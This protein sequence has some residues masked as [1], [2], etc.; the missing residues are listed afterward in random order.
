MKRERRNFFSVQASPGKTERR[1]R[2][3][4]EAGDAGRLDLHY[5]YL[6]QESRGRPLLTPDQNKQWPQNA[7]SRDRRLMLERASAGK[8]SGRLGVHFR[9]VTSLP[10]GIANSRSKSRPFAVFCDPG[11]SVQFAISLDHPSHPP[12]HPSSGTSPLVIARQ[13]CSR[14]KVGARQLYLLLSKESRFFPRP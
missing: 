14:P 7:T 9:N 11:H 3:A 13:P 5:R 8:S 6:F 12:P 4:A 2:V 1:K 10:T